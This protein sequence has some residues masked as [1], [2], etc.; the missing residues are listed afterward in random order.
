MAFKWGI[1]LKDWVSSI[2]NRSRKKQQAPAP[3]KKDTETA[4]QTD[5]QKR[6]E[7]NMT[8]YIKQRTLKGKSLYGDL[9]AYTPR[10]AQHK[11]RVVGSN[12][13]VNLYLSGEL[14]NA[15]MVKQT[16][17]MSQQ[18]GINYQTDV[19][20]FGAFASGNHKTHPKAKEKLKNSML[21]GYLNSGTSRPMQ[22]RGFLTLSKKE[23]EKIIADSK[24]IK[25]PLYDMPTIKIRKVKGQENYKR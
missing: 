18:V 14:L 9:A 24:D 5:I 17:P 23:M 8:A 21:M 1:G 15:F 6:M 2:I 12:S 25:K 19:G 10:Y 11:K 13:P 3:R 20:T 22:P 16:T 7:H 4:G